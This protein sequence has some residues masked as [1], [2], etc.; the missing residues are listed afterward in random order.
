MKIINK[1]KNEIINDEKINKS[2]LHARLND[3]GI[4]CK[5]YN[6]KTIVNINRLY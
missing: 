2:F 3:L 4:N 6:G 1:S 5:I